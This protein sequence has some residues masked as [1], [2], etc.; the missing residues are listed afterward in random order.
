MTETDDR[1]GLILASGSRARREM[2]QAAGLAFTVVPADLDE[3][4]IRGRLAAREGVAEPAAVA[5]ALAAAKSQAV[6]LD[7]P[8]GLVIGADQI[9]ALGSRICEK[10]RTVQEA[11]EMLLTL[12][13]QTHHLHSAVALSYGG[14]VLWTRRDSARLTMRNFSDAY[15]AEYLARAGHSVCDSVG[16]YQIEGI[17]VQL[18]DTVEGDFF[19]ILGMPMI[20]LLCELRRQGVLGT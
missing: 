2:L 19:T 10:P 16:A 4:A 20:P 7:H 5:E 13:G 9:L 17:G 15:L 11:H 6:S 1:P 18:F 3:A 12:R 14:R 8:K